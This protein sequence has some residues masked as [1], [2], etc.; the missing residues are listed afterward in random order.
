MWFVAFAT[1]TWL[2][3]CVGFAQVWLAGTVV[4]TEENPVIRTTELVLFTGLFVWGL[5]RLLNEMRRLA[6]SG[7]A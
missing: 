3:L 1:A 2:A 4:V 5:F 7:R 6:R